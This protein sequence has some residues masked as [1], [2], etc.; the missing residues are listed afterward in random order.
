MLAIDAG[1]TSITTRIR[2]ADGT[3]EATFDG[4]DTREPLAPQL[5]AVAREVLNGSP[6]RLITAGVSGL[7]DAVAEDHALHA[8]MRGEVDVVRT[9]HDSVSSF[10]GALGNRHGA[11][12]AVGTGVVTLAVGRTEVARID[13]WGHIMGDAG[14]GYWIGRAAL[15]SVMRAYDGRGPETSL[16]TPTRDRW[17]SLPDAYIQLQ[18]SPE[19]VSVVASFARHVAEHAEAGD[20]VASGIL[21]SAARE[22][23]LSIRTGLDRVGVATDASAAVC[24]IGGVMRST[25]LRTALE[26]SLVAAGVAPRMVAP[27]GDGL[28]GAEK[29]AD[30]APG[31]PLLAGA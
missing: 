10:L 7:T 6:A 23:A 19:R 26:E 30:L 8:L 3:R 13:G 25:G 20:R 27:L 21:D 2:D 31:H 22:L 18:A 17:P 1:Q 9:A 15:E 5:A 28:D 29:L 16:A 24:A 4:I 14:S 12:A 11:V